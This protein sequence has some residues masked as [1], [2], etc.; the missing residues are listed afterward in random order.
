[1]QKLPGISKISA[2]VHQLGHPAYSDHLICL[3]TNGRKLWV[4]DGPV[5]LWWVNRENST[6]ES[7]IQRCRLCIYCT[8]SHSLIL[9]SSSWVCL[10][11]RARYDHKSLASLKL[12]MRPYTSYYL[13]PWAACWPS[14]AFIQ[15]TPW[16]RTFY[17]VSLYCTTLG[18][19]LSFVGCP[20]MW[21]SPATN[22]LTLQWSD[23]CDPD[24]IKLC[25]Q[26]LCGQA[27]TTSTVCNRAGSCCVIISF[28]NVLF[29]I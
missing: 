17:F 21:A 16:Y 9:A 22:W 23:V 11:N 14:R 3:V 4:Y 1:M 2:S 19:R 12:E 24:A 6:L 7:V 5:K 20:A 25:D 10:H 26:M 27:C 29:E 18:S 8:W 28:Q 13:T 15:D